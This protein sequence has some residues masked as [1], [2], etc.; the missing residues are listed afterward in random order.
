MHTVCPS[1]EIAAKSF[2]EL[3]NSVV[4][5]K[6]L[7]NGED[8][9]VYQCLPASTLALHCHYMGLRRPSSSSESRRS[10][11]ISPLV[12]PPHDKA[13]RSAFPSSLLQ[14]QERSGD[15]AEEAHQHDRGLVGI[16]PVGGLCRDISL[17]AGATRWGCDSLAEVESGC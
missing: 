3:M 17:R 7:G 6:N 10:A 13:P 9:M 11:A 15:V 16:L 14:R 8:T 4:M 12:T 2:F 1:A 5:I